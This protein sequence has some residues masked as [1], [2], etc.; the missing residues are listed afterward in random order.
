MAKYYKMKRQALK[1]IHKKDNDLD[2]SPVKTVLGSLGQTNNNNQ[3]THKQQ[4]HQLTAT[5]PV[6]IED[7][8]FRRQ[9]RRILNATNRRKMDKKLIVCI[10]FTGAILCA[11]G[12]LCLGLGLSYENDK[13]IEPLII[14]GPVLLVGGI[15]VWLCSIEVCVRLYVFSRRAGDPELDSLVSP[16]DVK[17]WMDPNLIP[18]GW[19]LFEE[20]DQVLTVEKVSHN[21]LVGGALRSHSPSPAPSHIALQLEDT[22]DNYP[23]RYV[24]NYGGGVSVTG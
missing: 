14:I 19:G 22:L 21:Q 12:G 16:H 6:S 10:I 11:M 2:S 13:N 24:R 15:I 9:D 18:F 20:G 1:E 4:R 7:V 17:H 5:K 3:P 8:P 23:H